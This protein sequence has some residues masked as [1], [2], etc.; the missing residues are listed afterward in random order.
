[1]NRKHYSPDHPAVIAWRKQG[2]YHELSLAER[3]RAVVARSGGK[4]DRRLRHEA[5]T[6]VAMVV[7]SGFV[8]DHAEKAGGDW[9]LLVGILLGG[10]GALLV[11]AIRR[12][13]L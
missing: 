3:R 11:D 10:G 4:P 7:S 1:M 13:G 12:A 6:G 8:F 9:W 2:H 5:L